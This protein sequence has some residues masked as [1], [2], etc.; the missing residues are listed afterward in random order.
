MMQISLFM[1]K[2]IDSDIRNKFMVSKENGGRKTN[3][4]FWINI[5]IKLYTK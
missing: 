4:E 3:E 5:Y 1:G 2:Q